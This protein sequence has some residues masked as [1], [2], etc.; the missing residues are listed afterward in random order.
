MHWPPTETGSVLRLAAS[1]LALGLTASLAGPATAAAYDAGRSAP[2]EDSYYPAEGSPGVD[3]LHYGLRLTWL[4]RARVLKGSAAITLRATH[5][6]DR[7]RLDLAKPLVVARVTV[8]P[9]GSTAAP[10]VVPFTHVGKTLVVERPVAADAVYRVGVT[11]QGTPRP[12][13]APTG[14]TDVNDVGWHTQPDGQVW[15]M[16]EPFGAFTWYPCN[17]QPSD[18][19]LYDVRIS[20]PD[21]WVGISNGTMTHRVRANGRTVTTFT[22]RDPMASYLTTIAIGPYRRY[23][24]TGPHGLPMS[25][26]VP[27][28]RPGLVKPLL[29]TPG[30]LRWLEG[31]LGRYPFR[32]V[33]IVVTPSDSAMETQTMMTFGAENYRYGG[34]RYIRQT[35]VH[36]LAHSWYGDTVTPRDWRDV[37]MNEGMAT[38]QEIRYAASQGWTTWR[39]WQRQWAEDDQLWRD[40]YGP[41]GRYHRQQFA[42]INVY[43][44]PAL[45]LDR[46]R[47]R[48]G[49]ARFD[50]LVRDWP[51]EHRNR[52]ASRAEFVGWVEARTGV[53]LSGFFRS[54]LMSTKSPA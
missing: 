50:R 26:W 53:E 45:M 41:P 18:K 6:A 48:L 17:D 2:V 5:G 24:Q 20:A 16:Q 23:R 3:V 11:Y 31:R 46:L 15:A 22:N 27:R 33:G 8:A 32:T 10:A 28:T 51:Q 42:S 36:E 25:Y 43:Y 49:T 38:F 14:R 19:A 21:R 37:W 34:P 1:V 7:F 39:S 12:V 40:I 29:H 13:K 54:W 9:A 4:A 44:C 30:A 47:I 35:V 52:N